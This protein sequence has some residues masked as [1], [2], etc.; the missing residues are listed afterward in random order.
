MRK[1]Q[2]TVFMCQPHR[3]S[4][5]PDFPIYTETFYADSGD[6]Y[7]ALCEAFKLAAKSINKEDEFDEFAKTIPMI[8]K[9]LWPMKFSVGDIVEFKFEGN[10]KK[11]IV[12]ICDF[13]GSLEH[14]YHSYDIEISEENMLYKHIPEYDTRM[15][16]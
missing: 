5:N 10:W 9:N 1:Y 3:K 8:K 7:E 12:V 16:L 2:V 11:G 13:G 15:V 14:D 6:K 4:N